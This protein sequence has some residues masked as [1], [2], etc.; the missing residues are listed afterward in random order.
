MNSNQLAT[1]MSMVGQGSTVTNIC[2]ATNIS[3]QTLYKALRAL[4]DNKVARVSDWKR[5]KTGR[6]V[7]PVWSLGSEPS[8]PRP[9]FTSAEKQRLY[10]QRQA[11]AAAIEQAMADRDAS[12][13]AEATQ[14]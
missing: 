11:K 5:D 8:V 10:R 14:E 9:R 1:V 12:V 4:E 7:E 2:R 3:R 13:K 6:A